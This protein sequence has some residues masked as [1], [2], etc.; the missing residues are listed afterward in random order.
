MFSYGFLKIAM[1]LL[2]NVTYPFKIVGKKIPDGP[3]VIVANHYRMWDIVHVAYTTQEKIHFV[4]KKDLYKSKFIA[5]LC[6][7][8]EAIPVSR[9]GQDAKAVITSLRY[10]KKGEK[11]CV[12]PEGTR[13]KTEEELLPLKGGA[14]LFAIKGKVP[15][16]P[17]M[18]LN[19]QKLWRRTKII[20]GDPFE[21]SDYYDRKLTA[22]DYEEAE[23]RIREKMLQTRNDYILEETRK[24]AEKKSRKNKGGRR[25]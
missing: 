18:A 13:N 8:I 3:C 9:D 1:K 10:L 2:T 14:A 7:T 20:V 11:V 21:F 16:Y 4:A 15:V 24:K 12:F 23:K 5:S 22:E 25:S 17:V 19:R 6:N